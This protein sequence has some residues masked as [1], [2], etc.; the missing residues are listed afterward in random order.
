MYF[1]LVIE[2]TKENSPLITFNNGIHYDV[3]NHKL[4]KHL[5]F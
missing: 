3:D 2:Y 1:S 5:S 4:P